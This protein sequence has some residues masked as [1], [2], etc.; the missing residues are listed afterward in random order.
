MKKANQ[1]IIDKWNKTADSDWY[2]RYRTDDAIDAII[3]NPASA[4]H[5]DTFTL[6]KEYLGTFEGK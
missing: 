4:F 5:P 6:I 2:N 1:Q 3:N